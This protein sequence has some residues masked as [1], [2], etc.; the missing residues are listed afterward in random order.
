ME[1]A[2]AP[3]Q[4]RTL[5]MFLPSLGVNP[6]TAETNPSQKRG[7]TR[8][9]PPTGRVEIDPT[10]PPPPSVPYPG[11]LPPNMMPPNIIPHPSMTWEGQDS[12]EDRSI[13]VEQQKL[14]A[15]GAAQAQADAERLRIAL[16]QSGVLPAHAP[17]APIPEDEG[18]DEAA[19][20]EGAPEAKSKKKKKK[21]KPPPGSHREPSPAGESRLGFRADKHGVAQCF[22]T[23]IRLCP[24]RHARP[25][26]RESFHAYLR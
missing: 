15:Q 18:L 19:E 3:P 22:P 21:A 17:E 13:W 9:E 5:G 7:R 1:S 8:S 26:S 24:R 11:P 23:D 25:P 12:D 6:A 2:Q 16:S 20:A 14:S 4:A 10:V